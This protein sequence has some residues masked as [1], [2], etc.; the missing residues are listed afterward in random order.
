MLSRGAATSLRSLAARS[1]VCS[2]RP[3][4]PQQ[5]PYHTFSA[6][7]TWLARPSAHLQQCSLQRQLLSAALRP[8]SRAPVSSRA[9]GVMEPTD[10][11]AFGPWTIRGSEVFALTQLSYAFVN[12]KPV[13]PGEN[14]TH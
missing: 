8:E 2:L 6:S 14:C 10:A 7:S 13:V 9:S 11:H 12:L 5:R 3:L 4:T 1:T